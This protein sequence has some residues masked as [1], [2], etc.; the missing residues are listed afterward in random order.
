MTEHL[1]PDGA[2]ARAYNGHAWGQIEYTAA[3]SR[4]LL[5]LLLTAFVNANRDPK[6]GGSPLPW[7]K[8]SWRPGDPVPD[9]AQGEKDKARAKAAY[10][11]ILAQTKG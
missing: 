10:E 4:D 6:K 9:E 5:D 3:D 2:V 7:P 11:H 8:P 1:P